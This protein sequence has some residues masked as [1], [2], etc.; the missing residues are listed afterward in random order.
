MNSALINYGPYPK[1]SQV[2]HKELFFVTCRKIYI[3][4]FF[5]SYIFLLK[6]LLYGLVGPVH[7]VFIFFCRNSPKK[8]F[9]GVED[10]TIYVFWFFTESLFYITVV[11]A[12]TTHTFLRVGVHQLHI[13]TKIVLGWPW[14]L[15]LDKTPNVFLK[16]EP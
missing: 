4:F 9:T 1:K 5:W 7:L 12:I 15:G 3:T 10:G 6:Y 13:L 14:N 2:V 8:Y 16:F 11:R